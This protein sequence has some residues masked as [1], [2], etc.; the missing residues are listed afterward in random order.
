MGAI[1]GLLA[2]EPGIVRAMAHRIAHRS[3]APAT[4]HELDG[5]TLASFDGGFAAGRRHALCADIDVPGSDWRDDTPE[6]RT[7]TLRV[8]GDCDCPA[9]D[10][11]AEIEGDFAAAI[12]ELDTG[13]V[14]L[15]RDRAGARP[16]YYAFWRGRLAFASEYKALLALPG[17]GRRPDLAAIQQLQAA[18]VVAA[19]ATLLA[20]V[21][22]VPSGS[23]LMVDGQATPV[24]GRFWK[25]SLDID[26]RSGSGALS[27]QVCDTFLQCVGDRIHDAAAISLS[28]GVDSIAILAAARMLRPDSRILTYSAGDSHDDPELINARRAADH[29]RTEHHEVVIDPDRLPEIMPVLIWHLEDPIARTETLMTFELCRLASKQVRVLLRGDGA[30]GLFGG[31]ERH[32]LL[33][34]GG[35][36]PAARGVMADIYRFTQSGARPS[37]W[38]GRTLVN[39][40]VA[41]N[42]PLV[43]IVIGAPQTSPAGPLP[44]G[45]EMLNQVL[46]EGP[47]HALPMLLQKGERMH[48]AFAMRGL[49]PFTDRRMIELAARIPS[50][51]KHDG[52]HDKK[53]FRESMLGLLPAGLTALAKHP[54]R[55]RETVAFCDAL[56][57][58]A[59]RW[60]TPG[61][62][63]RRGLLAPDAVR[64][65][66]VRPAGRAW[67]PEHAMRIWTLIGTE[68]WASTFLDRDGSG[69]V[70]DPVEG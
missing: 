44:S 68:I 42:I 38:I 8:F 23:Y 53:I 4:I 16:L 18:K 62:V 5:I 19:E 51:Y 25:P 33:A 37:T 55:V 39:R 13:Q 52:W 7:A 27:K 36:L 30:D 49:S 60:L 50:R 43:P 41:R 63:A 67:K 17:I 61:A 34:I 48:A 1:C 54:Q 24:S 2:E 14:V 20:A 64:R 3:I 45:P 35:R 11:P 46:V 40:H 70:N 9:T 31:M 6:H 58:L 21:R 26:Q 29:F 32:R 56:E 22:Q 57:Q 28:G 47:C 10:V 15:A 59:G 12:I 69:P 65:M 66:L